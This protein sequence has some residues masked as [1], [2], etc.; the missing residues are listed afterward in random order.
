[1]GL[2]NELI[3][4]FAKITKDD[5]KSESEATVYG[6]TVEYNGVIY[7]Q[8]D[9]SDRL[10][11][12][13]TLTD[14]EPDERVAVMIKNHTA[15][16]TGNM[17]SPAART[18]DV[19]TLNGKVATFEKI[20]ADKVTTDELVA[21]NAEITNLKTAH[22]TVTGKLT[23]SEADI[24][25]LKSDIVTIE[26]KLT[27]NEADISKLQTDKLNASDADIKYATIADLNAAKADINDLEADV[28][29][30]D[31]L[32]FGSAS[33]SSIQT[34]FSN[35]VIAQLGDAQI[36]SAMI[37]S[38]S[39]SKITAGDIIT[40][41][42]RV[43]S[44]DGSLLISDETMQISDDTRVR[45]QIGKD[46]SGD[47]SINIW[48]QNGNLMFSKG[49]ITDSAIKDAIIR[50]D[51]VS[52]T[53]NIAA[54]KLD[55]DSL[56]EE[57]NGSSNT[58]KSTQVYLDDKKQTLDVAFKA[59][60]TETSELGET[61]TS[62]G[63]QLAAVQ[64]QITSKV[65]QQDITTAK[66]ELEEQT[67]T[68]STKYSTLEQELDG[69]S[70]TVASHTTQIA[71]KA[72]GSAVTTVNNKVTSLE[73]NLNGFKTTVS[74]TYATKND[75]VVLG[76]DPTNYSM[77]SRDS[78]SKWGFT[79]GDDNWYTLNTLQRDTKISNLY[80]CFGGEKILIE[81]E[82][83]SNVQGATGNGTTDLAYANVGIGVYCK[84]TPSTADYS[85]LV[86]SEAPSTADAPIT[87]ISQV[88]T[89]PTTARYFTVNFQLGRWPT[90]TGTVKIRNV[91]VSK[92][93][94]LVNRVSSAETTIAQNKTDIELRA[95]KTE[96][97]EAIGNIAIGGRNLIRDSKLDSDTD[98]WAFDYNHHTISFDNGYAEVVREYDSSYTSRTFNNQY[99]STNP[100]LLPDEI[101]G[102]TYVLQAELKAVEGVATS[103]QSTIFWRIYY[104]NSSNYEEIAFAIP[105]DLSS[106]SWR[107]CYATRTFGS[108][109]WTGSQITIAL[110]NVNNGVCV[111]NIMLE[112]ATKPST[113]SPAPEDTDAQIASAEAKI[114]INAESIT[115]VVSRTS[116][117]EKSIASLE[118]TAD[119]L[120]AKV[121]AAKK[122]K[123]HETSGT[124][125]T[126]GYVG[127]CTLKVTNNYT[128]RPILFELTNRGQQSSNVSFCFANAN[129]TDPALHHIQSDGGINVWAYKSAT[130]TW[131]LI[132]QK[133][134]AY[135]TIYVKDFSN[136]NSGVTVTW[137][138]VHY[139]SLPTSNIVAA[140]RL[141]AKLTKD[142]VD[143][144]AKTATNY[145]NFSSSGLVVGDMTASSLGKNV[146]I[147]SDSVDIRNGSTTLASFGADT[148]TL[149]QNAENSTINLCDGAGTIKTAISETATAYPMYDALA[150]ESQELNLL[151]KRIYLDTEYTGTTETGTSHMT[152]MST[153][154]GMGS[155]CTVIDTDTTN[156][157]GIASDATNNYVNTYTH[158]YSIGWNA[159]SS[160][161]I[162]NYVTVYPLRTQ[163][164]QPISI[165]GNTVTGANKVLWSGGY[166]MTSGH[167]CTLSEGVGDQ[168]NGIVLVFSEFIDGANSNTSFHTRFVPKETVV[169][170]PG[171]GHCFQLS[172]SNLGYFATKYLY[173]SNTK[174]TGHDNNSL[175]GTST[176]G[177]TKTNTRFVLRYVIGV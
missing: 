115:Q 15:T 73:A 59:I 96:V 158:L 159:S 14:V 7:V 44:E 119:G 122:Q 56:F 173:I 3:S 13:T 163:F 131:Q 41:N 157:T 78:A 145:L 120:T 85:W 39:A 127:I 43:K 162:S 47:Y 137:T 90:F 126:A 20:L 50:N 123:Y 34:S 134:E 88:V 4:Q 71:S 11:P 142:T 62:Q 99:S 74:D 12:I 176:C 72:D 24:S 172:S 150:I 58:I 169:D 98:F 132:V 82:Y 156:K 148:I 105:S 61:V 91:R 31:T 124:A 66:N 25:E 116:N 151:G 30:I 154:S 109:N 84:K 48:D 125:G 51:M 135:D 40:N 177:I 6:K 53:A 100:L 65:W 60:T 147:D 1:M 38:V 92:I 63:T 112:R 97:T 23:A 108:R 139:N 77:L 75:V 79:F 110:A 45:V 54:H 49:G 170:H 161:Y 64:G 101:S 166:Y 52:D 175:T 106:T 174:I 167:S 93:D 18:D 76:G 29:D 57:I 136:N 152:L 9:G 153:N 128:N 81:Y 107:R 19:Q 144:A 2:S 35:A 69:V 146:L 114:A 138:S 140:T 37:E 36:K 10:T 70:A 68:L 8:L 164:S 130:S 42:V 129:S 28:A 111:R 141:A 89:I 94:A 80:E 102:K 160:K 67:E 32:M 103:E 27:A 46:A 155:E 117:N 16:I 104:D 171:V 55:I 143:N 95:K 26:G 21:T 5:K 121:D 165:N 87:K 86:T 22:A 83:S 113:W 168:T 149:G 17:S 118:L 133:S 33:G